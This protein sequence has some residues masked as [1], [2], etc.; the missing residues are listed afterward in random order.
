M[1]LEDQVTLSFYKE[2]APL[3]DDN[4]IL[5]VQHID[6]KKLYIKKKRST[7][8]QQLYGILQEMDIPGIPTIHHI[9][10][11][12]AALIIIEDHINQRTLENVLQEKGTFTEREAFDILLQLCR[13]LEQLHKADPPII[14]RD[15]KPAN[16][17]LSP[18]NQVTLIDF[19]ASRTY[20]A[21]KNQDTVLMGTADYAAPEQFGF[22]QSD[23]RTDIYSLGVL[24][25]EMLT[26][27]LPKD[28]AYDGPGNEII[29]KC[30]HMDPGK[31]YAS[32]D[33]LAKAIKKRLPS[34]P[35]PKPP[36]AETRSWT[37]P[38]FR[39][40]TPWKMAIGALGY[41]AIIWLCT[42]SEFENVTSLLETSI[43][44][45]FICLWC[46]FFVALC[47]NYRGLA[48][49]LPF[50]RHPN[51]AF[52]VIGYVLWGFLGLI[53]SFMGIDIALAIIAA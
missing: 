1:K 45:A 51:P 3:R 4:S 6:T 19:N 38:G 23:A 27:R 42:I 44:R 53:A 39:T 35:E 52:K 7:Y 21:D 2:L 16:I 28:K 15:I 43:N 26:G 48:Q 18:E 22:G 24:L 5:L 32:A 29:E 25:N 17:L 50:T 41:I 40:G 9:I 11:D 30:L 12:E 33:Q 10:P 37:P 14:H 31:R 13:I 46:L 49:K 8:D 34:K 47:T 20:N 36:A